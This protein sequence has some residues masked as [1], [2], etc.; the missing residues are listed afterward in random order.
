MASVHNRGSRFAPKFYV[1]IKSGGKWISRRCHAETLAGAR[2]IARTLQ[3]RAERVELGLEAPASASLSVRS[4][5]ESWANGLTNRAARNDR[6]RIARHLVPRFG[7]LRAAELTSAAV[8]LWL[9]DLAAGPMKPG[10]VRGLLGLLSRF[11]SWCCDRAHLAANPCKAIPANRRPRGSQG[12]GADTPWIAD[13]A[14]V[15]RI[16]ERLPEPIRFVWLL[17]NRAGLRCGEAAGLRLSDLDGMRDGAIRVR[18]NYGSPMLKEAR[19]TPKTKWV[20]CVSDLPAFIGEWIER[21][22]AETPDPETLA[23]PDRDG[24]P[25]NKDQVGAAFRKVRD[26]LGLPRALTAHRS[27]RHSFASRLLAAGAGVT[28]VSSALGHA[29]GGRLLMATYNHHVRRTW[30]PALV[31]PMNVGAKVIPIGARANVAPVTETK[32]AAHG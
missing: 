12:G 1:R 31:A 4:L 13:D 9:D 25:L 29:D 6:Y 5:L 28:E 26:E 23:F 32:E 22:R 18:F 14:T 10:S 15:L 30:S 8:V 3:A 24:Y 2:Q 21:R 27:G 20:P 7:G 17:T 16:F 19:G 11:C